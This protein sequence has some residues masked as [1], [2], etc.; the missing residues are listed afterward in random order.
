[1]KDYIYNPKT[2]KA[3]NAFIDKPSHALIVEGADGSGKDTTCP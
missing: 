1:M 2:Q 3:I